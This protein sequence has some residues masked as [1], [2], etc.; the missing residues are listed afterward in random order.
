ME[1]S[2]LTCDICGNVFSSL[3][4]L[5]RHQRTAKYCTSIVETEYRCICEYKT[6]LK[7]N[8]E[9]HITVCIP[10]RTINTLTKE[11]INMKAENQY[12]DDENVILEEK[13]S[14][15]LS[16]VSQ[17][18]ESTKKLKEEVRDLKLQ[19]ANDTGQI[20]VYKQIPPKITSNTTIGNQYV[21]PKLANIKCDT[22]RPF[23]IETVKEEVGNGS[24]TY[25]HFLKGASGLA[26]FIAELT[27][28]DDQ[29]SYVCTDSA[30]NKF[31][32][33]LESRKWKDDNG[34]TF[35]NNVLNELATSAESYYTR[36][37]NMTSGAHI[38]D[39]DKDFA[40]SLM[41]RTRPIYYA[42]RDKKSEAR[43]EMLNKIRSEVKKL[44][45][46]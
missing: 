31:H 22:I 19:I 25:D 23:T 28:Q 3:P 33:L 9:R 17:Y 30:R 32:R 45:A 37:V 34:A 20:T 5:Y 29:R 2:L 40:D 15:A 36:I 7:Q 6:S 12:L 14:A 24:Y 8:Y 41:L 44:A 10:R 1:I 43:M 13:L 16:L 46:V 26:E 11:N 18:K 38:A 42:I 39:E 35:L 4:V 27:M 21:N